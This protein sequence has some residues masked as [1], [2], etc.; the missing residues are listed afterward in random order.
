MAT[1]TFKSRTD[2]D[3]IFHEIDRQLEQVYR[4]SSSESRAE[5]WAGLTY[6]TLKLAAPEDRDYVYERLQEIFTGHDRS[7]PHAP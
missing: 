3:V 2:L 4:A 6:A 5:V 1:S 7:S